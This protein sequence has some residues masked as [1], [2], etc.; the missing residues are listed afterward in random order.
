[1]L[2]DRWEASRELLSLDDAQLDELAAWHGKAGGD[3][4][5][6]GRSAREKHAEAV[7]RGWLLGPA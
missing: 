5:A 1:M 2:V 3:P 7:R 6:I 4:W